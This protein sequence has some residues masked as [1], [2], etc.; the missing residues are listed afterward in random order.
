M[1]FARDDAKVGLLVLAAVL[2]FGALLFQRSIH[3]VFKKETIL[4]VRLEN[5]GDLAVGTEVHLQGW[6]VGQVNRVDLEREGVQYRFVAT[7]GLLPEILLW[8]GTKAVV[9]TK[10]F[11]GSF[12][13]LQLPEVAARQEVLQPGTVLEGDT[14]ASLASLIDEMQDFVRNLNG[15][16]TDLRT[17]FKE[18]G[19]GVLLDHP[20][21]KKALVDLDATLLDARAL[22]KDGQNAVK[23]T[24]AA[25]GRNLESLEKSLSVL[26]ALLEK[27]SGDV[28]AIVVNLASVLKQLDGL[29]SETRTLLKTDGPE[30]DAALKALRRNLERSEELLELLKAKPNRIVWGTPSEAE[31]EAARRKVEASRSADPQK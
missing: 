23:H 10:M 20:G 28:D 25:L 19:A 8:K 26:Q 11:G 6:R 2:L 21:L 22:I 31:K 5:A 17:T 9:V 13:D 4:K 1:R 30:I 3:A 24:D 29:S 15:A 16:L 27:R 18:K 12:V 7:L 14:A